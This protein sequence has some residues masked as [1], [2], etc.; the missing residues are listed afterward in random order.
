[1]MSKILER[2][3]ALAKRVLDLEDKEL[4][5]TVEHLLASGAPFELSAKEKADL[6]K[7]L[8]EHLSGKSRT[9]TLADVRAKLRKR[10]H[11]S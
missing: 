6:D 11:L 8:H 7:D 3:V 10:T 1:M 2:K 4:L 9:Y 5:A